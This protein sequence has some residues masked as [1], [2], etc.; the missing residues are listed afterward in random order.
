M[1]DQMVHVLGRTLTSISE[2]KKIDE[3][4]VPASACEGKHIFL[5][6]ADHPLSALMIVYL[7]QAGFSVQHFDSAAAC[8]QQYSRPT[9]Y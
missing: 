9:R 6:E 4:A 2:A 5:V 3:I 1:I 7:R 8:I